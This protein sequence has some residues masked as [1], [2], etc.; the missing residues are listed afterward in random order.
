[1]CDNVAGIDTTDCAILTVFHY[2]A[3]P[4]WMELVYDCLET[5]QDDLP[6]NGVTEQVVEYRVDKLDK[7]EYLEQV[8]ASPDPLATEMVAAYILTENGK[9]LF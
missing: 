4:L 6:I 7:D 2:E 9:H 3:R 5:Y 8:I 1:M